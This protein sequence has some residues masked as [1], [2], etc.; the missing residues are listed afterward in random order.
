MCIRD[1]PHP[2]FLPLQKPS[3]LVEGA[4]LRVHHH[5][6]GMGLKELQREKYKV[7]VFNSIDFSKSMHYNPLA[8][9]KTESDILKFVTA[10]IRCV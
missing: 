3:A 10:L 8:Y 6:R 5:I 9:L 1:S 7:R 4:A 2:V